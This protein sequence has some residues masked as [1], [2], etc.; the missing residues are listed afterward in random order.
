MQEL[1]L[2][3]DNT[4]EINDE[5]KDKLKLINFI[6]DVNENV[7]AD[8]FIISVPTPID[9]DNKPDLSLLKNATELVG[10]FIKKENEIHARL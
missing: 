6:S 2:G 8:V 4:G 9:I 7:D 5:D 10:K 1:E 3:I